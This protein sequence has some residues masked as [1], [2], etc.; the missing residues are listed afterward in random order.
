MYRSPTSSPSVLEEGV[1]GDQGCS[2]SLR[3]PFD[4][5]NAY[6]WLSFLSF[7]MCSIRLLCSKGKMPGVA[8]IYPPPCSVM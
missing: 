7:V 4:S 2:V 5:Y 1:L 6:V 3:D 8:K